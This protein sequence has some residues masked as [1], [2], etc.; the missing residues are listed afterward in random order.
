MSTMSCDIV[1]DVATHHT[2]PEEGFEPSW[3]CAQSILSAPSIPF[4]H[5]GS[6][7]ILG[8]ASSAIAARASVGFAITT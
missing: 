5:S 7:H 3:A 1:S 8:L 6:D 4:L 2:V